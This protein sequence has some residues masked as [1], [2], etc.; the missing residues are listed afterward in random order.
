M[1][2]PMTMMFLAW[3]VTPPPIEAPDL[4]VLPSIYSVYDPSNSQDALSTG[5]NAAPTVTASAC[6]RQGIIIIFPEYWNP[7]GE[8]FFRYPFPD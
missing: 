1:M 3:M 7:L 8:Y 6:P 2:V 4:A 5:A